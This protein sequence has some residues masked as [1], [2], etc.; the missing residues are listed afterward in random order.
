F[1]HS[2]RWNFVR[3]AGVMFMVT[4]GVVYATL[5]GGLFNPFDGSHSWM[6]A[7]LHQLT[8][9]VM[10]VDLILQPPVTR[11]S[12]RKALIWTVYPLLFLV[13]SLIRGPIVDWYPYDFIDPHEVGGYGGV[14]M[15]SVAILVGFLLMAGFVVLLS[16]V[17]SRQL[18][19]EPALA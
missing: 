19:V 9:I 14:A 17:A 18:R 6:N 13:Y 3:G 4:T 11:L 8:P 1:L 12:Y 15:Y 2:E 7:V 5:L 16:R 10:V